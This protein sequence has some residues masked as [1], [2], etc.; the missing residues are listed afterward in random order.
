MTIQNI[1]NTEFLTYHG[2]VQEATRKECTIAL[3]NLL[4]N[5]T[6]KI[7]SDLEAMGEVTVT[8]PIHKTSTFWHNAIGAEYQEFKK[9]LSWARETM[10]EI[11][12]DE[13]TALRDSIN[14]EL[15]DS[16]SLI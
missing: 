5:Y 10:D 3:N 13:R 9:V 14:A 15:M 6:I 1:L 11:E 7:G 2:I 4:F 8:D 12:D 16:E